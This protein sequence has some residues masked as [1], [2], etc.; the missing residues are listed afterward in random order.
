MRRIKGSKSFKAFILSLSF[1]GFSS[2][3]AEAA[4]DH[5]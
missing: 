3:K 4:F 5:S 1:L 2:L